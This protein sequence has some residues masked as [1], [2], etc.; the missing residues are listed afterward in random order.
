MIR[1]QSVLCKNPQVKLEIV[2]TLKLTTL[3]LSAVRPPDHY[4]VKVINGVFSSCPDIWD[5]LLSL[6]DLELFID[7]SSFLK[8]KTR[9]TGY[10]V[11]TLDSVLKA[12]ALAPDRST[13]KKE[14]IALTSSL[15]LT[16]C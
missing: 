13:Q 3:L 6:P 14:L 4:C 2:W 11:V 10:T 1:Y 7:R 9:Y 15:Q 5:Q 12:Q 8:K 16:D